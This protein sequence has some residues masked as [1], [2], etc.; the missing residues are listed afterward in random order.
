LEGDASSGEEIFPFQ[1]L[2]YHIAAENRRPTRFQQS[3]S[4]IAAENR[5][6]NKISAVKEPDSC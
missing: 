5:R 4:W 2:V 3:K 1:E 6:T